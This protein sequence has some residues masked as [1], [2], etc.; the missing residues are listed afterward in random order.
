MQSN[1]IILN[2]FHI[3]T[4]KEDNLQNDSIF[5]MSAKSHVC[6]FGQN[7]KIMKLLNFVPFIKKKP[8]KHVCNLIWSF[9]VTFP[10]LQSRKTNFKMS[11]FFRFL[12]RCGY[13]ILI[14]ILKM[15][16]T[17]YFVPFIK[18][19]HLNH[20]KKIQFD[21]FESLSYFYS[22]TSKWVNFQDFCYGTGMEFWSKF[23][24]GPNFL[25]LF[26]SSRKHM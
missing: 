7:L 14:K 8:V 9:W 21:H 13:A 24:N 15:T 20:V 1:L 26:H 18:K 23:E 22:Q 25:I 6:V 17:S 11:Q 10:F 4:V 3:F 2:C 16:K 5:M 19:T 12:P